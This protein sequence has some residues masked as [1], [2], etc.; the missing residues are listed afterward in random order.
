[1]QRPGAG[2][3]QDQ[4][5]GFGAVGHRRQGV[6]REGRQPLDRRDAVLPRSVVRRPLGRADQQVPDAGGRTAL[7]VSVCHERTLRGRG[8][9]R[10]VRRRCPVRSAGRLRRIGRVRTRT[11]EKE[12]D[13]AVEL[14]ELSA[15]EA[16]RDT[17]AQYTHSGD[18]YL[19]EE[20][21]GAFCE[22]GVLEIRGA[23]PLQGRDGHHGAL[24][25]CARGHAGAGGGGATARRRGAAP[26]RAPQRDQ[27]PVRVPAA[28]RG[29]RRQL[30]HRHHRDRPR[31]H[32]PLPGP[33]RPRGR[34]LADCAPLRVDRLALARDHLRAA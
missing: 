32:G 3:G 12:V 29:R 22:D 31:P 27:H 9:E 13:A 18:R 11:T 1:M 34:P 4:D 33:L 28:R 23:E 5:D 17:L 24:R 15:R 8:W 25:W 19:L 10:R 21:A 2:H 16:C 7:G 20:F 30:L 14:W 6:E 26:H